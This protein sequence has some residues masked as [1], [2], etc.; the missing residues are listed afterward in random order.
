M[1]TRPLAE[2]VLIDRIAVQPEAIAE[3]TR[4]VGLD[5][6]QTGGRILRVDHVLRGDLASQKFAFDDRHILFG[7][8]RPNLAKVARPDF[9]GICSTDILP[10]RPLPDVDR[11]Y[12]AHYLL[13]QEAVA[14]ATSRTSGANLPRLSPTVLGTMPVPLPPLPEQRRIASILDRADGLVQLRDRSRHVMH[15]LES[16]LFAR[17]FRDE[18]SGGASAVTI[19]LGEIAQCSSGIT[20]GRRTAEPTSPTPYMAVSNVQDRRLDLSVVKLI[21]ATEVERDRFRLASGDL[22]LTEG[23]DPDKLGRGTVWRDEIEGAIHQNHIF[24]VRLTD[25][26]Y[27]PDY[28]N[29][30][31]ASDYGKSYF[32]SRAKQTTGIATINQTQLKAFP[33]IATKPERQRAFVR[34]LEA[35]R[36]SAGVGDRHATRLKDLRLGLQVRAFRGEL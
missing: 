25:E 34:V 22:L 33:V 15:E 18:L 11:D 29:W 12:L 30:L 4:Y 7:K 17:F 1:R 35:A 27:L 13:S 21:D 36:A 31:L 19:P 26:N 8:L 2:L 5:C 3:G 10:I 23:G 14:W 20:K 16:R 6:I 28:L 24:R 9:S 32:L